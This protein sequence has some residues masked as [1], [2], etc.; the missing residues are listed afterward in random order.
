MLLTLPGAFLKTFTFEKK[1]RGSLFF[2]IHIPGNP[3]ESAL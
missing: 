3:E 2:P 1:F